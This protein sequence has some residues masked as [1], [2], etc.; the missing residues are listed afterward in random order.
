MKAIKDV[1]FKLKHDSSYFPVDAERDI[2]EI[3][4]QCEDQAYKDGWAS[5]ERIGLEE[6][7]KYQKLLSNLKIN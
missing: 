4:K 3:I 2:E 7:G 1:L 5:A 6:T